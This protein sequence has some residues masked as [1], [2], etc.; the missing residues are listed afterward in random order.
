MRVWRMSLRRTNMSWL[1]LSCLMICIQNWCFQGVQDDIKTLQKNMD[2]INH[3]YR[4]L[5]LHIEPT[6]GKKLSDEVQELNTNWNKVLTLAEQQHARL[7]GS[8]DSSEEIFNKMERIINWLGPIND[9]LS[10]KDYAVDSL[11]DLL[12]KNKKFKVKCIIPF[13]GR[14]YYAPNFEEVD[15]AYWFR[16]VRASVGSRTVHARV[17]KFHI[18]I[19]HGKYLMHV[20]FLVRVISL[21][22]VM[23]H[24]KNPNKNW[25]MPYL[26]N[27]AF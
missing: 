14:I 25:C 3:I 18:W 23:P 19:P 16:V 4:G 20:F 15:G 21:S 13:S 27:H 10:N 8:L 24:W 11:N 12:V 2:S 6:F 1:S 17:L 7:K 5:S 22:G 26:M 9:D